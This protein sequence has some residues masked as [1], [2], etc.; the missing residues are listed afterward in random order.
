MNI[1]PFITMMTMLNRRSEEN[2]KHYSTLSKKVYTF[3]DFLNEEIKLD[4][5]E[6]GLL[7]IFIVAV[8]LGAIITFA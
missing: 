5:F 2:Q 3:E 6:W 7:I 8:T 1:A 4:P